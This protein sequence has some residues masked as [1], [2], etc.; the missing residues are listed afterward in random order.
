MCFSDGFPHLSCDISS[1]TGT[2]FQAQGEFFD[3]ALNVF[4]LE[5][6]KRSWH[7]SKIFQNN[8]KCHSFTPRITP[9]FWSFFGSVRVVPLGYPPFPRT[10]WCTALAPLRHPPHRLPHVRASA[11]QSRGANC[12]PHWWSVWQAPGGCFIVS[13]VE[14]SIF[15]VQF[16]KPNMAKSVPN[17]A[18]GKG[19]N[20]RFS[21]WKRIRATRAVASWLPWS[22]SFSA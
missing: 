12:K 7:I 9:L 20:F 14:M 3:E 16:L 13:P 6:L 18:P 1:T 22:S 5:P 15:L 10:A 17:M 8:S 19:P 4:L 21:T 11:P 2:L